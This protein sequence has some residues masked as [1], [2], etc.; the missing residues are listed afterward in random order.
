MPDPEQE[1]SQ[2]QERGGHRPPA[3][4]ATT[5]AA[6]AT[7]PTTATATATAAVAAAGTLHAI[8][9]SVITVRSQPS[10]YTT[11]LVDGLGVWGCLRGRESLP[12]PFGGWCVW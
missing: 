8:C 12:L 5:A 11:V 10:V 1:Q 2:E 4:A 6:T 9:Q 7:G 3:T